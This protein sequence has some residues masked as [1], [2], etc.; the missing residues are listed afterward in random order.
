MQSASKWVSRSIPNFYK[1]SISC[2]TY[3]YHTAPVWSTENGSK[4]AE[5]NQFKTGSL[6]PQLCQGGSSRGE[7]M[8]TVGSLQGL[9]IHSGHTYTNT[10]TRRAKALV[11]WP[12]AGLYPPTALKALKPCSYACMLCSVFPWNP[13]FLYQFILPLP[14]IHLSSSQILCI[15]LLKLF[16]PNLNLSPPRLSHVHP[17]ASSYASLQLSSSFCLWRSTVQWLQHQNVRQPYIN[18]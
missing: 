14:G 9:S 3:D 7:Q 1:P 8:C 12:T 4:N 10:H 5:K 16:P 2:S 13:S 6:W 15:T 17:R 11:Q 18:I